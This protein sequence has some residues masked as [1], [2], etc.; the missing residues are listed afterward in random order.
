[1]KLVTWL[2]L[3]FGFLVVEGLT[4]TCT[5]RPV[6]HG[7]SDNSQIDA[8][9]AA[10]GH[11]GTTVFEPGTYNITK[12]MQWNLVNSRVDLH[13]Q[14]N[15]IFDLPYWMDPAHTYRAIFIQSQASWFV[16]TGQDFT[17]DAHG[18]GGI[19]G[20]GQHWWS[21]YGNATRL[22]G[23][24]RPVALSL[25]NV[26][27][28]TVKDFTV[29]SP[30]FWCN[31]VADAKDVV[32]DGMRCVAQNADETYFGQNI[33]W[34]TDGIDTF[35][36]DNISLLN[37]DITSGDDCLAIKGNST[38]I[39][40]QNITCRGGT[41]IAFGSLG[42]YADLPDYVN[43]VLL[44]DIT[45]IQPDPQVQPLMEHGVYFKS[46]TGTRIGFPPT[47]GGA[48]AG[49]VSGVVVRN[50]K[51]DNVTTPIQLYQTNLGHPGDAPSKLQFANLSFENWTGTAQD[52][53]IIDFQC[54]SAAPC[55]NLSFQAIDV[56][57]PNGTSSAYN[58][59][60]V[61]SSSG[62]PAGACPA[63]KEA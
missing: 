48:G 5:L 54:S 51:L 19:I 11:H 52:A 12:K 43:N 10:C 41:G 44:E 22:D 30:P 49:L 35:R 47:G 34:N 17:I 58:C 57:P 60:N 56:S 9:I 38:N 31:A 36:A 6:G 28:G 25:V 39:H 20:N 21:W 4:R 53:T 26:T 27:R 16:V 63:V 3:F 32:Y 61:A 13:G 7:K 2:A 29:D 55:E 23:D 50:V 14:L 45:L 15:F 8:A 37:F 33:V 42:Q 18:T 1:M 24:G 40:A 62:L 59:V 46:W